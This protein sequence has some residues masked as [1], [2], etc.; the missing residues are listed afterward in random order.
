MMASWHMRKRRS[1][2]AWAHPRSLYWWDSIVPDFC[3]QE[4]MQNFRVSRE[5]FDYICDRLKDIMGRRNTN[6]RLSVPLRKRVAIAIWKLA[7]GSEYRTISH[8]FGVGWSTVYNCVREFCDAVVMVL[9]PVHITMPDAGKLE[10]L[11]TFFNNRWR[12]P[13][14]VGAIDG[15]HIPIIA[16]EE[17]AP[18]YY[19]RK[20]WHLIVLQAVVDGKGMFWDWW[21]GSVL[22]SGDLWGLWGLWG[23]LG[24]SG[25]CAPLGTSGDLCSSEDLWGSVLSSGDL[26]GSVLSSG[27]FWGSVLLWGPLG[28]CAPLGT[29]PAREGSL[30]VL[31]LDP[32]SVDVWSD[33]AALMSNQRWAPQGNTRR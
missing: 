24:T 2:I 9:L 27:D 15:S 1:P 14:C 22:S 7:T 20:G 11:A 4:F 29:S 8:L 10:E 30:D 17:C 18:E 5:S 23:P 12:A 32:W 31:V 16:P 6:F 19:N 21:K 13:Q 28:I 33:P 26:W 25:I 3:R